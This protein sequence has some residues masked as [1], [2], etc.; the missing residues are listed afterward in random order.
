MKSFQR[1]AWPNQLHDPSEQRSPKCEADRSTE[2][3]QTMIIDKGLGRHAFDDLIETSADFV[4][5]IK[6]GFGTAPL[7]KTDL[8]LYKIELAKRHGL[9]VMPG[10]TLLETAVSQDIVPLFFETACRLG[11]TAIEVSDGTIELSRAKRTEL[12]QEGLRHGLRVVTEYGKKLSGSLVDA[13]ELAVTADSDLE[14]GASLVT[15][16]A[17]ESGVGVGLFDNQGD[18]RQDALESVCRIFPETHMLMWEAPLKQQQVLLLQKFGPN[19][20]LGNIQPGEALA[21]ETMRRGL[22]SDTFKFGVRELSAE[23]LHYMI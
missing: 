21:L 1:A 14:A 18:C 22:R 5:C 8:L 20:H 16:E 10:G 15:I 6:L 13:S 12:I 23:A 2:R 19:V 7:Y 9:H 11:F 17:R 4:D 3:G